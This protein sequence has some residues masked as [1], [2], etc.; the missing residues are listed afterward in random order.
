MNK[1]LAATFAL[2]VSLGLL[3]EGRFQ[4]ISTMD[5]Q[6]LIQKEANNPKFVILD[7]RTNAEFSE[8][9]IAKAI[10]ID[11]YGAGFKD[12]I[13]KLP[14]DGIYLVYCRSGKRSATSSGIMADLAFVNIINMLGGITKWQ[15]DGLPVVKK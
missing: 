12:E 14:K 10:N 11:F 13:S 8:G 4:N 15:S 1:M 7:V 5:A 2:L 3:A 6:L 9:H